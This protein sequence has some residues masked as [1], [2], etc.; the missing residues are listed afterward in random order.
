VVS[1]QTA[2]EHPNHV[3][4]DRAH[5]NGGKVPQRSPEGGFDRRRLLPELIAEIV[6]RSCVKQQR[7]GSD[8]N[9]QEN[10]K[11]K[12]PELCFRDKQ[13][14]RKQSRQDGVHEKL[15]QP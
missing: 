15:Q 5:R 9:G 6:Q 12:L 10:V 8:N 2:R 13:P 14:R 3:E 4:N 1:G 7:G 11:G